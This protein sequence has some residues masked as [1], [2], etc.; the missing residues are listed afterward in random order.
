MKRSGVLQGGWALAANEGGTR[1]GT[2]RVAL[3]TPETIAL[4]CASRMGDDGFRILSAPGC[5]IPLA[6]DANGIFHFTRR[7]AHA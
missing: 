3:A 6:R 7:Q 5:A 4:I 2:D 1:P